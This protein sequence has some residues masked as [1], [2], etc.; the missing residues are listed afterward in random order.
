MD[1][2]RFDDLARAFSRESRRRVLATGIALTAAAVGLGF[3]LDDDQ[4]L[5]GNFCKPPGA[6]CGNNRQCCAKK[7]KKRKCGCKPNGATCFQL[8][9]VCCSGHCGRGKCRGK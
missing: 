8:G 4:A 6:P 9:I 2:D 7:C 1:V 3:E 5:A